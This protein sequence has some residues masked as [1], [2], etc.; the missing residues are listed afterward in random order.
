MTL[1]PSVLSPRLVGSRPPRNLAPLAGY[2]L[3]GTFGIP[4]SPVRVPWRRYRCTACF[5]QGK[6]WEGVL[7][8]GV[9]A[10][11]VEG[12]ATLAG[13][14][15]AGNPT[16]YPEVA[17]VG[18]RDVSWSTRQTDGSWKNKA[19]AVNWFCL[20]LIG[21]IG[22]GKLMRIHFISIRFDTINV[23][24]LGVGESVCKKTGVSSVNK[25]ELRSC[26]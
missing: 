20:I 7:A 2:E 5:S 4:A 18:S 22:G 8:E 13:R 11:A 1:D 26:R 15:P 16:G 24:S 10:V 19:V 25:F 9:P 6:A 12:V 21:K 17:I 23:S 3:R 14:R